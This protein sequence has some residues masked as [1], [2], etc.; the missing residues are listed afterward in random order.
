MPAYLK[1][2]AVFSG[3]VSYIGDGDSLC[4]AVGVGPE[5]WVEV[6]LADFYSPELKADGGTSAKATLERIAS[7]R[8]V[9]C[10]ADHPS[11]DRIVARCTIG[12]RSIGDLMRAAGIREGGNGR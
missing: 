6:R 11:Y 9:T 12:N 4:V 8:R 7:G 10:T 3:P 1:P 2:G 5:N